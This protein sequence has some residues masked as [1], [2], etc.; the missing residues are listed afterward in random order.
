MKA[1][2]IEI[3]KDIAGSVLRDYG[4]ISNHAER[5][6]RF[7]DAAK[8]ERG[9]T[10]FYQSEIAAARADHRN[11]LEA[12]VAAFRESL[13]Q[14]FAVAPRDIRESAVYAVIRDA[15]HANLADS[16]SSGDQF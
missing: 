2:S 1:E 11:E 4:T 14:L 12:A 9:A 3:A 15:E 10:R 7:K 8:V 5:L 6:K 16:F 13:D